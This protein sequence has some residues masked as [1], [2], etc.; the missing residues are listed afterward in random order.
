MHYDLSDVENISHWLK[1]I[2]SKIDAPLNGF[3]HAA[4]FHKITPIR[5]LTN[6]DFNRLLS[7][8]LNAAVQLIRGC[9]SRNIAADGS[10]FVLMSSVSAV[11]G[12]PGLIGYSAAKG[13]INSIVKAAAIELSSRKIRVNSIVAGMVESQMSEDIKRQIGEENYINLI[14]KH[15]LGIGQPEDIAHAVAF[16]LSDAG[17]WITGTS[18]LIDGGYTS[19]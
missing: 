3:I 11:V 13:A 17:R 12:E 7:I 6:T 18:L 2:V 5:S 9:S 14:N 10:S 16:L 4:G 15:P 8:H 1:E 19:I